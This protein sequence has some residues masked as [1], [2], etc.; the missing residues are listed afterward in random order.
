MSQKNS[1]PYWFLETKGDRGWPGPVWTHRTDGF[2]AGTEQEVKGTGGFRCTGTA[3]F[4]SIYSLLTEDLS[5]LPFPFQEQR[6]NLW[7]SVPQDSVYATSLYVFV[8]KI[9]WHGLGHRSILSHRL[10]G[11]RAGGATESVYTCLIFFLQ[12]TDNCQG[13]EKRNYF[14]LCSDPVYTLLY[15]S[16]GIYLVTSALF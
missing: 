10:Q 16:T 11:G 9:Q 2:T 12:S 7:S 15:C 8:R 13:D 4:L 6:V 5:F 3:M 1:L 14:D